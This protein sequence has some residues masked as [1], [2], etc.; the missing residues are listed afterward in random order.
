MKLIIL[1]SQGYQSSNHNATPARTGTAAGGM[2]L[3]SDGE[4]VVFDD[5]DDNWAGLRLDLGSSSTTAS[6]LHGGPGVLADDDALFQQQQQQHQQ[7]QGRTPPE[8]LSS[9]LCSSPSPTTTYHRNSSD[10]FKVI[11]QWKIESTMFK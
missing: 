8:P 5:I 3:V 11:N 2:S 9:S 7:Q 4:V 1:F 10:F 6:Q